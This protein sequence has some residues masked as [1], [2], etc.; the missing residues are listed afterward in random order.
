MPVTKSVVRK[1]KKVERASFEDEVSFVLAEARKVN[2]FGIVDG[3]I[4]AH[5]DNM[6]QYLTLQSKKPIEIL[7][8]TPGGSVVE[9]LAIYDSIQRYTKIA[10]VDI[11]VTGACMSMGTIILQSARKRRA[12]ANSQFLL[13]EVSYGNSGTMTAHEDEIENSK[14][15][16]AKLNGMLAARSKLS[17]EELQA[18]IKRKD[19]VI[20]AKQALD[21]RLIDEII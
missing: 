8:N 16:Q 14:K 2:L 15:L 17:V 7:M 18:L 5:I 3:N 19:H 4:F 11:L 10:P 9:G 21:I 13:H 6:L 1:P 20:N 12:T